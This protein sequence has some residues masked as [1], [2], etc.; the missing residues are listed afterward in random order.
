VK[1]HRNRRSPCFAESKKDEIGE[2]E[3][4]LSTNLWKNL[5]RFDPAR[6]PGVVFDAGAP[7]QKTYEN[8]AEYVTAFRGCGR[9]AASFAKKAV[10]AAGSL[11]AYGPL[12]V[13]LRRER[14]ADAS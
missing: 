11:T 8:D 13:S 3:R 14:L 10:K 9:T 1:S 7:P 12:A 2:G 6:P 4:P 5:I